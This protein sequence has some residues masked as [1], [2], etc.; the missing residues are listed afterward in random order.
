MNLSFE[1]E[2]KEEKPK[3]YLIDYFQNF[4]NIKN[5]DSSKTTYIIIGQ[6]VETKKIHFLE[7]RIGNDIAPRI[8]KKNLETNLI[9]PNEKIKNSNLVSFL[10][11]YNLNPL[12][13][14]DTEFYKK[15]LI[16]E[17]LQKMEKF[18]LDFQKNVF[19]NFLGSLDIAFFNSEVFC[20]FFKNEKFGIVKF[21]PLI[22]EKICEGFGRHIIHI[23]LDKKFTDFKIIEKNEKNNFFEFYDILQGIHKIIKN[24]EDFIK[25]N[26]NLIII[27]DCKV[28]S[29][30]YFQ[31]SPFPFPFSFLKKEILEL[32]NVL[33]NS[34]KVRFVQ[35][36]HFNP[37]I[38][39]KK[40]ANFLINI[41]Y[42]LMM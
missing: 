7:N 6:S 39:D 34:N 20:D 16:L 15:K 9:C 11:F 25:K 19:F 8:I 29:S 36:C 32:I 5:L 33:K 27:F 22:Y 24:L 37:N 12:K 17:I 26:D 21:S 28:F 14:E 41:M 4:E 3:T 40:S 38:E 1:G 13:I 23:G 31:A 2:H 30:D 18:N 35:F 10:N 42:N